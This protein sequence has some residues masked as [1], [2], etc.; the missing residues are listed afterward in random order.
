MRDGPF[1]GRS[2][3]AAPQCGKALPFRRIGF[4]RSRGEAEP[5]RVFKKE[6]A[7]VSR[8]LT[9]LCG[10]EAAVSFYQEKIKITK[11]RLR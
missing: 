8:R 6:Q 5:R 11:R 3:F 4:I 10:G 1:F 7:T 9:A 2:G